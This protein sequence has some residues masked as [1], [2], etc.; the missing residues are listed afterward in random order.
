MEVDQFSDD[1]KATIEKFVEHF[2]FVKSIRN[3]YHAI[4]EKADHFENVYAKS[5]AQFFDDLNLVLNHYLYLA[6]SRITEG[7]EDR[8][9][10][11]RNLT[12]SLL[13][14][15]KEWGEP[16]HTQLTELKAEIES[17]RTYVRV[18]RNRVIGHN[19]LETYI[20][21]P[22]PVG[23]FP[24]G[25]DVRLLDKIEQFVGIVYQCAF[26][27]PFGPIV[28]TNR[29]D[30]W[31]LRRM[32]VY[33]LALEAMMNDKNSSI[34]SLVFDRYIQQVMKRPSL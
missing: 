9:T 16:V 34:D 4:F 30:V 27:E 2:V 7:C 24:A 13:Y 14:N 28:T 25:E 5:A 18:A 29:G 20:E 33:G 15:L 8:G 32:L 21:T 19:D 3:S 11:R 1:E 10:G 6:Y 26:Q 17:F 22:E 12:V 23:G 31:D